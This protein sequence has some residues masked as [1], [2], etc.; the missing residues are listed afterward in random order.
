MMQIE[1][2][3][4]C[5][6]ATTDGMKL[7]ILGAFDTIWSSKS[8]I[9][10]PHC[11]VAIRIRFK[12]VES[13]EHKIRLN[14]VNSDG[15]HIVPPLDGGLNLNLAPQQPS[16]S[17]NFVLTIQSLKVEQFGEY[18]IDLAIDGRHEATLP[19]FVREQKAGEGQNN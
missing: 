14:I 10:F 19:L 13:G 12:S 8:P 7:N 11:A 15:K 9:L 4:L 18:S 16:A 2:F 17:V 1:V 3:S 6:A 5:D